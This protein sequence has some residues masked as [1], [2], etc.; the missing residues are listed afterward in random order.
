MYFE[1][2]C[3]SIREALNSDT[4]GSRLH[5]KVVYNLFKEE[6]APFLGGPDWPSLA[7]ALIL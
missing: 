7:N 2:F 6:Y 5:G 1:Y 4:E 3:G